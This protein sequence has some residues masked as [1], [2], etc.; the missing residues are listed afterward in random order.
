[1]NEETLRYIKERQEFAKNIKVRPYEE[2]QKTLQ[3]AADKTT[4][5]LK[6][7]IQNHHTN[8]QNSPV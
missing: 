3:E 4:A 6:C 7:L 5:K 1:M 8:F 2:V